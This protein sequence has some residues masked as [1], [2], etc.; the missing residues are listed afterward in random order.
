VIKRLLKTERRRA[1][2]LARAAKWERPL[3]SGWDR[4]HAWANMLFVDHGVFRLLY[5]NRA[6][7]AEG[8]WRSSQ[9]SPG[10]VA[11]FAAQGGRTVVNL[12]GG[13]EFGS[14]PL[15]RE[16]CQRHGL[17]LVE[18]VLRSREAPSRETVLGAR[19]LFESLDFPVLVH[20]KSG[21]DRV[22]LFAALF[23]L[24]TQKASAAEARRQLSIRF[25]HFRFAKTG[26]LDAFLEAYAQEGEA[27]GIPFLE[28]V[29]RI[30]DP[31][32]LRQRFK[33]RVWSTLVA[34][35][36]IRRE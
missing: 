8:L 18:F 35:R 5:P 30:Y 1:R 12:R 25:G 34:D 11:R 7:V 26:I 27:R 3:E 36:L 10:Q 32:T 19:E 17:K 21:A 24:T 20:C 15:Q 31:A 29:E 2:R 9:P 23:L 16:A 6:K 22:G 14:W 28:W 13:R 33:P 4:A